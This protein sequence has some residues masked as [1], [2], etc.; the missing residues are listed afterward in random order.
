MAELGGVPPA[1]TSPAELIA[2]VAA[3]RDSARHFEAIIPLGALCIILLVAARL[4]I[5]WSREIFF[6][7]IVNGCVTA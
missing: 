6:K 3:L 4:R 7:S 1:E 5:G 2:A